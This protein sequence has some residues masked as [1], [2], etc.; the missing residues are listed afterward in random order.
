MVAVP[1]N[2]AAAAREEGRTAW[3]DRLP[4]L[5][6]GTA[7]R[8]SV[9]VDAPLEPGGQTAWVAPARDAAGRELVVKIAWPHWEAVHEADGLAAWQGGGTVILHAVEALSDAAVLLLER[10]LPGTGLSARPEPEQDQVIAGLLPRLWIPP[11]AG[12]HFRPLAEMCAQWADSFEAKLTAGRVLIDRGLARDGIALF[13][14]LPGTAARN[15]LLCTDLHA[16]NVLA[17]EREPWLVIDPKPHV[18]DPTYDVLQ[19]MLNCPGRLHADPLGF[20]RRMAELVEVDAERLRRWLFARCVQESADY[21][22]LGEVAA[23]VA[24]G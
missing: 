8:W 7:R 22:G 1:S 5:I 21:P 11:P 24:P 20:I 14:Q 19:H 13:R 17:A 16:E 6:A 10:C 15:V 12:R 9:E 2:L 4:A 3:L 23:L 18:G